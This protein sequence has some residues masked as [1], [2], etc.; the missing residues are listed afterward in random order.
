MHNAATVFLI[1]SD[2]VMRGIVES[3]LAASGHATRSFPNPESF[4]KV[5]SSKHTGCLLVEPDIHGASAIELLDH[6][7]AKRSQLRTIVMSRQADVNSI[8]LSIKS[9]AFDFLELPMKPEVLLEKVRG[10]LSSY[11]PSKTAPVDNVDARLARLTRREMDVLR[12]LVAGMPSKLIA[13][14]L[15]VAGKTVSNHRAHLLE[16]TGAKNTAE[17]VRIAVMAGVHPST[18]T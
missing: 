4:L 18:E 9:G 14:E 2:P 5:F 13:A 7:R 17:L 1:E 3:L 16:K 6:L 8:V 15:G 11:E 10:A 12:G